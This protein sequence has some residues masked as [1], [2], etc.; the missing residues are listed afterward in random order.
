MSCYMLV[1]FNCRKF[2]TENLLSFARSQCFFQKTC[3]SGAERGKA[4][5]AIA[6][7]MSPYSM[8]VSCTRANLSCKVCVAYVTVYCL[9]ICFDNQDLDRF[10]PHGRIYSK[11]FLISELN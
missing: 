1:I 7:V 3:V 8:S 4:L 10:V 5:F 2:V 9:F 6:T 11:D